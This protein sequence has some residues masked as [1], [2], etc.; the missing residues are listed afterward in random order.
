MEWIRV[1]AAADVPEDG[2]LPVR[3]QGEPVCL[4]NLGGRIYATHDRCTHE[5]AS[6]ADGFIVD[7]KIECPLHQGM[8]DIATGK[9]VAEPCTIDLKVYLTKV[10]DGQ[11]LLADESSS[12]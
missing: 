7:G 1:A 12:Q 11:V 10:E 8:F 5:E 6:L 3:F 9:A 2:T 4:Y